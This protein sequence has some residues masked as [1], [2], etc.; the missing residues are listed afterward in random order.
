MRAMT[1]PL[2]ARLEEVLG[3]HPPHRLNVPGT[4]AAAVL[5]P[6]VATPEP[7]LIFTVRTDTLSSHAGQ[8]SFP[9]GSI[10]PD[11]PSPAAAAVREAH[12]E[13]GID[14][15]AVR[16]IGELDTIETFVS[17]YTVTPIVGLLDEHPELAPSPHEV[18]RVLCVP[19]ARLVDDIRMEPGFSYGGRTYPT[20]AWIY[21]GEVIWGVTARIIR[22][23]LYRLAEAGLAPLPADTATPWSEPS[24][25][26]R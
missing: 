14:A 1:D 25:Q 24:R 10:D 15:S 5:I 22:L 18:A 6:V 11:D 20:E 13:I 19:L 8:I 3:R 4:R 2:L 16:I 12:E 7:A 26:A 17:G 23:L 21:Q 9:G